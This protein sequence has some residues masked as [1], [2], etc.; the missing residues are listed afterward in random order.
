[1][2]SKQ[3]QQQKPAVWQPPTDGTWTFQ[4]LGPQQKVGA[5]EQWYLR[6][7][8]SIN[9][10]P[11]LQPDK[12]KIVAA[13]AG[14]VDGK[15]SVQVPLNGVLGGT[16]VKGDPNGTLSAATASDANPQPAWKQPVMIGGSILGVILFFALA[17]L[18]YTKLKKPD[19]EE[20][21]PRPAS[22]VAQS[23]KLAAPTVEINAQRN[24]TERS[25]S[26]FSTTQFDASTRG[27][28]SSRQATTGTRQGYKVEQ[29]GV[30]RPQPNASRRPSGTATQPTAMYSP[31]VVPQ[32]MYL[33]YPQQPPQHQPHIPVMYAPQPVMYSQPVQ[34]P[35]Y[36]VQQV[37]MAPSQ[38]MMP[39]AQP[40][41][42]A[43][44]RSDRVP[45][46]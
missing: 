40:R 44:P 9:G 20:A 42:P 39:I 24:T 3:Q 19:E 13:N 28:R 46:V 18:L 34:Q 25:Q 16:T 31:A 41:Q 36:Y 1:M 4:L 21:K 11:G 12:T 27:T 32:Q 2:T 15:P 38:P 35:A 8:N 23:T 33:P 26:Q 10:D 14:A 5:G 45:Y 7:A 37:A 22:V 6:T 43:Y 29:G 30:S 17:S